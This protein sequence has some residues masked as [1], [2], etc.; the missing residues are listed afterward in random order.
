[1]P[2]WAIVLL[3]IVGVGHVLKKANKGLQMLAWFAA[4]FNGDP[5]YRYESGKLVESEEYL[6][7]VRRVEGYVDNFVAVFDKFN[8]LR[9]KL[10]HK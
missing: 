9:A 8:G 2:I 7:A 1:M 5:Y 4:E 6:S 3:A 10:R